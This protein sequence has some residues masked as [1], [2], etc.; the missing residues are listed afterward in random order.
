MYPSRAV[1][2]LAIDWDGTETGSTL[3]VCHPSNMVDSPNGRV[4]G[5]YSY[6]NAFRFFFQSNSLSRFPNFPVLTFFGYDEPEPQKQMA[7]YRLRW[8]S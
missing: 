8:T 3:T 5:E 1:L 4:D 6:K 2:L 7:P